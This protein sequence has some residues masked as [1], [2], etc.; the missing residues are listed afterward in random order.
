MLQR[1][2]PSCETT[3]SISDR[4]IKSDSVLSCM[5]T[6]YKSMSDLLLSPVN[7]Q[8]CCCCCSLMTGWVSATDHN[9]LMTSLWHEKL[10]SLQYIINVN[11]GVCRSVYEG[12]STTEKLHDSVLASQHHNLSSPGLLSASFI[13][14]TITLNGVASL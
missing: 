14:I 8:L 1:D 2:L 12:S 6:F 13:M 5:I 4:D 11:M 7:V 3:D 9:S 10:V